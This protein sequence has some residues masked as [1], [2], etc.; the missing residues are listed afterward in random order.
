MYHGLSA[1]RSFEVEFYLLGED[2]FQS[3]NGSSPTQ[4]GIHGG[5]VAET[6]QALI[7]LLSRSSNDQSTGRG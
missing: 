7:C 1:L 3:E 2:E 6:L 4:L 5:N